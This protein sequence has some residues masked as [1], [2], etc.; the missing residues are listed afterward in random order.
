MNIKKL[1]PI[2]L[3]FARFWVAYGFLFYDKLLVNI[4][5]GAIFVLDV[6]TEHFFYKNKSKAKQKD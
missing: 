1:H 5:C 2:A 4:V 3:N 6:Y